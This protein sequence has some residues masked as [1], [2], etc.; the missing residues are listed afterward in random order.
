[1]ALTSINQVIAGLIKVAEYAK[2]HEAG[3]LAYSITHEF[4]KKTGV[5]IDVVVMIEKFVP[6]PLS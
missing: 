6:F 2:E 3:T 5:P 4:D 1:M